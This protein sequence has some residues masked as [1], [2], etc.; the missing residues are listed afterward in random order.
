MLGINGITVVFKRVYGYV[1]VTLV[2]KL[3]EFYGCVMV[4]HL[5]HV[6]VHRIWMTHFSILINYN[7]KKI[8]TYNWASNNKTVVRNGRH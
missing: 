7:D 3:R 1:T 4:V 8:S 2:K 5:R 6:L